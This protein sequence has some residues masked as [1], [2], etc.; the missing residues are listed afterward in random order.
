VRPE[1][2]AELL[3]RCHERDPE[4][5]AWLFETY[6]DSVYSLALHVLYDESAAADVVQEVFLKLIERIDRFAGRARFSS[7]LYRVVLNTCY[8]QLRSRKSARRFQVPIDQIPPWVDQLEPVQTALLEQRERAHRLR[9][10]VS[11]LSPRLRSPLLLRH[12]LGLSYGE[13]AAALGI[14]A[15]TVASRLNRAHR[16]IERELVEVDRDA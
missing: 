10:C 3:A 15:G 6:K 4:A 9:R 1:P 11:R 16:K 5:F 13:I 14:T 7:W 8:D 12:V 2:S